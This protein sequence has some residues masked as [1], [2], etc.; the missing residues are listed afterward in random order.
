MIAATSL[1]FSN[2]VLDVV[3]TRDIATGIGVLDGAVVAV[4]FGCEDNV[5][6][7]ACGF[8]GPAAW[9]AGGGDRAG[10]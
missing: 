5:V 10:C 2:H 1:S 7:F 9:I 3:D 6:D 8:H 4:C